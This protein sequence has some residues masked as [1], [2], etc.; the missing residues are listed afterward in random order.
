MKRIEIIWKWI[1]VCVLV[2]LAVFLSVMLFA[3]MGSTIVESSRVNPGPYIDSQSLEHRDF[4]YAG[5]HISLLLG[6]LLLLT[7]VVLFRTLCPEKQPGRITM[8]LRQY[9]L[10]LALVFA[11]LFVVFLVFIR[12]I[13]LKTS[14]SEHTS[15]HY[16]VNWLLLAYQIALAAA[17]SLLAA[18]ISFISGIKGILIRNQKHIEKKT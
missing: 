4:F 11:V 5:F 16:S 10:N 8:H 13:Q 15:E 9:G 2:P 7:I 17:L 14:G 6:V 3:F 18:V 1:K 12:L